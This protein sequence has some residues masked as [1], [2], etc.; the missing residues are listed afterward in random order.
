MDTWTL[1]VTTLR[2]QHVNLI[3]GD[4]VSGD[5]GFEVDGVFG[6]RSLSFKVWASGLGF[7]ICM[8]SSLN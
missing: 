5:S 8:G 6:C 3:R 7:R 1:T 4:G 2:T